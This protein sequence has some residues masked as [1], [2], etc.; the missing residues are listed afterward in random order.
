MDK[1]VDLF[2]GIYLVLIYFLGGVYL[3]ILIVFILL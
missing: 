2:V 3:F 1:Y